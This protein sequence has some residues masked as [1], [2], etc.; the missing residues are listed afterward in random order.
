MC[1]P[2][3][4]RPFS[5]WLSEIPFLFRP[6]I[7]ILNPCA[8]WKFPTYSCQVTEAQFGFRILF[9]TSENLD[10]DIIVI[11]TGVPLSTIIISTLHYLVP[12]WTF[13]YNRVEDIGAVSI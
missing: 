12:T 9:Q 2:E 11:S 10:S 4:A 3:N 1:K 6:V 5:D 13:P 7:V 8:D